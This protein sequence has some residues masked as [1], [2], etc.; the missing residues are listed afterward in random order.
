MIAIPL[1]EWI[2]FERMTL[3]ELTKTLLNLA[4]QVNLTAF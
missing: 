1:Q 2:V 4:A 3:L